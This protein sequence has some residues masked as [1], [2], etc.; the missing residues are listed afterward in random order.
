MTINEIVDKSREDIIKSTVELLKIKS[1]EDQAEPGKPFGDGVDKALKYTLKLCE[2]L[3]FRTEN[4]DGYIGYCEYGKGEELVGVLVHLDVVP[5]GEG[6]I[7]PPYG[8]EIHDNK[9]YARGAID[10]KGPA[11]ACIYGLKALKESG[12]EV[13]KRIRLIFGTNEETSWKDIEHYKEHAETPDFGFTP[14]G[15]FPVING[16][17]GIVSY[18]IRKKYRDDDKIVLLSLDGGQRVNMVPDS[19]RIKLKFAPEYSELEKRLEES[20]K[21]KMIDFSADE[22]GVELVC[23]GLSTHASTPEFGINAISRLMVFLDE[24]IDIECNFKDFISEYSSKIGMDYYGENLGCASEDEE[25]GYLTLNVGT[26]GLADKGIIMGINIRYPISAVKEDIA[27]KIESNLDGV[28]L[29]EKESKQPVFKAK[30]DELVQ[31]LL[32]VYRGITGDEA[33][34]PLVIGGGTYARAFENI[35]AFGAVYPNEEMLAHQKDENIDI[36]HLIEVAKIYG[37]AIYEIS[38]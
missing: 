30:D 21:L 6:W 37:Q 2:D 3:G 38:K 7:Y 25:S 9:I 24:T 22:E 33:S 14:D 27:R 10:D 20:A 32:K 11:V 1:V 19:C 13:N 31:K 36:D 12:L 8:A 23:R 15:G 5:E 35:L 17:K 18:E 34:E 26:I 28:Q 4:L 16:E 29:I